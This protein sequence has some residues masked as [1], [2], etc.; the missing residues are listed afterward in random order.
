MWGECILYCCEHYTSSH[1]RCPFFISGGSDF[2][3]D[4]ERLLT[5]VSLLHT[6]TPDVPGVDVMMHTF[7]NANTQKYGL[8]ND[9]IVVVARP[10]AHSRAL[11]LRSIIQSVG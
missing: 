7:C 10:S 8:G 11:T 4:R 1:F 2:G 6:H 9:V 5:P 3:L